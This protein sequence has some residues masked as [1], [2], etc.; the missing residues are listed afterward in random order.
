MLTA[1]QFARVRD[2]MMQ[3]LVVPR[4]FEASR[5][6]YTRRGEQV[7]IISFNAARFGGSFTVDI[8]VHF[9]E[10][11]PFPPLGG[12][13]WEANECWLMRRLRDHER[14][15]FFGYGNSHQE[16]E[17]LVRRLAE[18]ALAD[19]AAFA[20]RW[21][22]GLVLL[23]ILTPQ[24]LEEDQRIFRRVLEAKLDEVEP[25]RQQ[26]TICRL[27]PGWFPKVGPTA[28][29]LAFLSLACGR[30]ALVRDYLAFYN[31]DHTTCGPRWEALVR[32]LKRKARK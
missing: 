11:P 16:A 6:I 20:R 2:R 5:R 19:F 29:M 27:F 25:L 1:A 13:S 9:A 14:N 8:G 26:M 15:Q 28:V 22:D 10:V 24:V 31:L 21:G 17:S 4:G 32:S 7:H 23:D 18:E 30:N 3:V 12:V